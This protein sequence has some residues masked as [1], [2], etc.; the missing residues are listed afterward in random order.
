M[1]VLSS[2]SLCSYVYRALA[3][4]VNRTGAAVSRLW[5]T[6]TRVHRT[7][8]WRVGLG[9]FS[10]VQ[11]W[12]GSRS[13]W[14][15]QVPRCPPGW[16][17]T[18]V[19]LATLGPCLVSSK[20]QTLTLCK[21]KIPRHIKLAVHAWSTKCRRNQKLIAQFVVLYESNLLSLISQ[22]LDNNSQ[23]QTKRYS[24]TLIIWPLPNP[25]TK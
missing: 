19:P 23:I 21:K 13:S 3:H 20:I 6:P 4:G 1:S 10:L 24:N 17:L 11:V 7:A 5:F 2:V 16:W 14:R 8:R 22:C 15:V 9:R 12:S 25:G 18:Q